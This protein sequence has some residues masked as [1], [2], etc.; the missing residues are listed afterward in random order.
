MYIRDIGNSLLDCKGSARLL[1]SIPA[2]KPSFLKSIRIFVCTV[3]IRDSLLDCK[4][5]RPLGSALAKMF[6]FRIFL[7]NYSRSSGPE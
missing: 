5:A 3:C 4:G 2:E 7:C 6:F 1:G